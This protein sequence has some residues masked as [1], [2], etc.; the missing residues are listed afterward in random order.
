LARLVLCSILVL[1]LS[2]TATTQSQNPG[3]FDT[4]VR[5]FL[6]ANCVGCHNTSQANAGLNLQQFST[7][8]SVSQNRERWETVLRKIAS[9]EM[10]PSGAKQ[11]SDTE[12][13]LVS[14]WLRTEF[15]RLDRTAP[16]DPGRVTARRL[17]R[18]EYN[19]TVA[20]LLGVDFRPADDFPQD[21]AGYGFDNNGDVLSLSVVQMEK[22]LA[23]AETVA[24]TA[25]YGPQS[26]K[27]LTGRYQPEGRRRPGDPDNLFLNGRPY[28]SLTNYDESGLAMPNSFHAM[29]RFP[30]TG[31]YVIRATPDNGTRPN[32][33]DPL[34]M[35]AFVDG[36]Q[37]GVV[38]IDGD[39]EGKTQ[40][41]R[42]RV[43]AGDHWV[44]VGFPKQFEGLPPAYGAK[45]PSTRPQPA[46]RGGRGG[47]GGA[48]PAAG[49]GNAPAAPGAPSA[50]APV[51]APPP[52]PI[53]AATNND[54]GQ[55][56]Q[57]F[58]PPGAA[59]GTR[60]PRPDNMGIQSLEIGGPQNPEVKPSPE[61]TRKIFTCA[62]RDDNCLRRIVNNLVRR[63]YRAPVSNAEVDE[64]V[65]HAR[66]VKQRG[67]SFEEQ[68]VIAL[69]AMLVSPKFL[70]RVERDSGRRAEAGAAPDSY[71][72]ND[73]ELASRLSY[74][75]WSSLPDDA[76]IRAAEQGTLR[77][78]EVLEA[79]VRRMLLDP[80]IGRLVENFG[81][82]WLQFRALES[83][84]P[85][86]YK[87]PK[88]DNYMRFSAEKETR[89]FF[90]NLIREDR[91]VL[92]F[93]DADYTFVNEYLAGYYGLPD[94]KGPEFRRVSLTAT[95]R[96]GVLG[97][98]SVLTATSYADRTSVV[99]RGKWI[100]E[101]LLNAAPPPPPPDVPDLD[102]N[103]IG[104]QVTLRE[105][106]TAHRANPLC[107]SCHARM[108]PLG[109]GLEN[110]NGAG[111]WRDKEGM[112]PI[113]ASGTL[114]GGRKF[115][116]PVEL[117]AYLRSNSDAFVQAM[118]EKMLTYALGR[119]L[120]SADRPAVRTIAAG[121]TAAQNRFSTVVLGIVK[122][123]PFQMRKRDRG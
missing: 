37:V 46:P 44:A 26:V 30:A 90:E 60:L 100:L 86:F 106:M 117:S 72:L 22:Y 102:G 119:G 18:A 75:L 4:T 83:H 98:A 59:P 64:I 42:T 58:V 79:Q 21:D 121:V 17:N 61:S 29:H 2:L 50:P 76:L 36:V 115:N 91:S 122:S 118:S 43:T 78:P 34:Q 5:P 105:R 85:D 113:D 116:G 104:E 14:A 28:L 45:N 35:A 12:R 95:P 66:R 65:V 107:A 74:F 99:L 92:D 103:G 1:G 25:V 48:A 41:F 94:V 55:S 6:T 7:A 89:M 15:D 47:R 93:L 32:V 68:V 109:F 11:P 53:V 57:F 88:W 33:S 31:D 62:E 101:N 63:A 56:D 110:Y 27:P 10:P 87:F 16:R 19:Y 49:R 54:D 77:R 3:N 40:E 96:R 38:S 8:A 120:E 97:Q 69:Q 70:F 111:G 82:Q 71:Y 84:Q 51:P 112:F 81:G 39:F 80:K 9:S 13:T 24:R 73:H 23:A 52:A 123:T 20:D 108:D 67:D 114:P